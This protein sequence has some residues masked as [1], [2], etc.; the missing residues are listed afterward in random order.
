MKCS[1]QRGFTSTYHLQTSSNRRLVRGS[2]LQ[3]ISAKILIEVFKR[4]FLI[5]KSVFKG[6]PSQPHTGLCQCI[7]ICYIISK[8][9]AYSY[10]DMCIYMYVY[11]YIFSIY[12]I[13]GQQF[14]RVLIGSRNLE[15]PWIF[16]VLRTERKMA[17][18]FAK[19][20]GEEIEEAFFFIHLIW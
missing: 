12:Q 5:R 3:D 13:S 4:R 14:L 9:I 1:F 8:F 17:R 7:V 15:Y 6:L 2:Q 16:T 18:R 10:K 11:I 19:F 20:S